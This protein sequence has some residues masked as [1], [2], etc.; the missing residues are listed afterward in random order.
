[1]ASISVGSVTVDV[2]PNVGNFTSNLRRQLVPGATAIGTQMGRDISRGLAAGLTAPPPIRIQADTGAASA[3][4][5]RLSALLDRLDGRSARIGVNAGTGGANAQLGATNAQ[6]D[7][8]DGRNAR[9]DV[10]AN[11]ASALAGIF[12]VQTA[13]SALSVASAP[14]LLGIGAGVAGLAGPLAAAGVGFGGLAAVA[15]PAV[16]RIKEALD[17]QKQAT[18]GAGASAIQAQQRALALAGAQQ[19]VASAVRQAG[20]AHAQA[21]QQVTQAEQQVTQAQVSAA[22]A[23]RAL[24]QARA[25]ARRA[26][27]D[28]KN[29][30][31]D[32][33]LAVEQDKLAVEQAKSSYE[34]LAAAAQ[35]ATGKVAAAQSALAA[36]QAAQAKVAADP[37]ATEQA[38]AQAQANVTAAAAAVSAADAQK[39]AADQAAK[40][41][42]LNYRQAV[43]R[44]KEQQL[45]LRRLAQ[46]EKAASKAGVDG[47]DQVRSARERLA[48]ANAQITNSERALVAAR[49]NVAR[50]DQQSAEQVAAARRSL[51]AAALQGAA[52]NAKLGASLAALTPLERQ[53]ATAWQGLQSAFQSWAKDLQPD[54]MPLLVKGINLIKGVLP[55]LTP[56]VKA[57]AGAV[58]G[59]LDQVAAA[60]ASPFWHQFMGFLAQIT[61]PSISGLGSVLLNLVKSIAG[62]VQAFAPI[63]L[64]F[65]NVLDQVT[66]KFAEF[67]T[68]LASNPQFKAFIHQMADL[69]PLMVQTFLS[70]GSLL[71]GIFRALA[72]A[73][74]PAL[75]LVNAL[76]IALGGALRA[77]GP[78]IASVVGTLATALIPVVTALAPILADVVKGLA[79][80][81]TGLIGYLKPVL[82]AIAPLIGAVVKAL[83][84]VFAAIGPLLPPLGALVGQLGR[85][86]LPIL[87]PIITALAR[88]AA[89]VGAQLVVALQTALPSLVQIVLAIAKLLPALL[90]LIPL[91]TQLAL[92]IIPIIPPLAELVAQIVVYVV[93][94]LRVLIQI[95]AKIA[96]VILTVVIPMIRAFVGTIAAEFRLAGGYFRILGG[97][98]NVLLG[99]ARFVFNA[100][101]RHIHDVWVNVIRPVFTALGNAIGAAGTAFQRGASAIKSA[102]DRIKAYTKDPVNFV[103]GTVYNRGILGLWNTVMGWL[104]L[105]KSLQ[106]G[107]IPLLESGG[108][109]TNPA[110]ARPMVTNGPMAIVGEGRSSYPE[111]VIPTDPRYRDRAQG[112]WASAGGHLQMLAGGGILGDV[113]GGV[114]KVAG[115]V[116][117]IGKDALGLLSNPKGV[118]DKLA[119]P[120]LASARSLATGPF[121]TAIAAIPP[122][123]LS[124]A[125]GVAKQIISTFAGAF[126]GGGNANAVVAAAMSQLGVPYSWGGGGPGGPS[127][128]IAQGAGIRGFDCSSLMQYAYSKGAKHRLSRT[129]YTQVNEGHPVGSQSALRPGDLVFPHSGHVMMVATPGAQGG[130]GMVEAP[131]T[132]A[133]VRMASFRGMGAGARRILANLPSSGGGGSTQ[134]ASAAKA[135]ARSQ[136]PEFGWAGGQFS[137]L[138]SLWN[139]ESGWRWNARNASS[140]AYGI[141]QSLPASKMRSAGSDYLSNG[142]T[143]VR[144][145]LGYIKNRYGSPS[146]A[147]AHSLSTGWYDDGGWL[148]P[149]PSMVYN[150]TG[151]PEAVFTNQQLSA[152]LNGSSGGGTEYHAHFDGLTKSTIQG[153]V[154]QA[155]HTMEVSNA[156]TERIGR[157][158]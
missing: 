58:G 61:G 97:V 102:W 38:K 60:A 35:A 22:A 29:Q 68:G 59:F 101:G 82:L 115:G 81:I 7:R 85:Q 9:V 116:L 21:E 74:K 157:R 45:Q 130:R 18:E 66:A 124:E 50:T 100:V 31:I 41:A 3:E 14:A 53:V 120:I 19:Q 72:P 90:P 89:T 123:M 109:L 42:D 2:V 105:P 8:L 153:E 83:G 139:R 96:S 32:A 40:A 65:L 24:T 67:A 151:E 12:S 56:I 47:S 95:L 15:I 70:V 76:A 63:G 73:I 62:L 4:L 155:F 119:G 99:V 92:A 5:G 141:P 84:G 48:Q 23:Q 103:I 149:G 69:A 158:R 154:R 30:L 87:T 77:A 25:E 110:P 80:L 91:W 134:S 125:W 129:T 93:P 57:A 43:Q 126:G 108:T 156:L 133:N 107:K 114:K 121:G 51:A 104:H 88:M 17:A 135:F 86:L 127:Y 150:G 64:I 71:G 145:G 94:V 33:G 140:G 148:P 54:V 6:V 78:A 75:A 131:H 112:L 36:A 44:L 136:M 137:P 128:G 146:K 144:W 98:F 122:R 1:M 16:T 152:L 106:L 52:A 46:D 55:A 13:M 138:E 111:Y 34:Q 79:P 118:W 143:Q 39:K 27:E 147:W 113:L 117:N 37:A 11:V 142:I 10:T 20:V 28:I 132:G 49:A 26:L